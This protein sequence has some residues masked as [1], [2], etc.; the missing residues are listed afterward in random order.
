M[1]KALAVCLIAASFSLQASPMTLFPLLLPAFG[2]SEE[3]VAV[4]LSG[5]FSDA[6]LSLEDLASPNYVVAGLEI[7]KLTKALGNMQRL[8][9]KESSGFLQIDQQPLGCALDYKDLAVAYAE[10]KASAD[11]ALC[12]SVAFCPDS[13]VTATLST[14][15][16]SL[17]G[18]R[19]D[20]CSYSFTVRKNTEIP[21][22]VNENK[23][24]QYLNYI[25]NITKQYDNKAEDLAAVLAYADGDIAKL[26]SV[27]DITVEEA[28]RSYE[29]RPL[30]DKAS[31]LLSLLKPFTTRS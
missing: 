19:V 1:N 11:G 14:D 29:L 27:I 15:S 2:L 24:K 23:L 8:E 20:D 18:R 7:M 9:I 31:A 3:D 17:S 16:L 13:L 5:E 25:N 10:K 28:G 21:S 26:C 22:E 4:A 12:F 30:L 6:G